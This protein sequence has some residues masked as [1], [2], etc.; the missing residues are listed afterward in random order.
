MAQD[1][2]LAV[3]TLDSDEAE[4]CD[5]LDHTSSRE[6]VAY[7]KSSETYYTCIE[8]EAILR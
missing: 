1:I 7:T 8:L 2:T 3:A 5:W 6:Q 4:R